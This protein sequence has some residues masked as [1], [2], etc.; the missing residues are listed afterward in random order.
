MPDSQFCRANG[1]DRALRAKAGDYSGFGNA[2]GSFARQKPAESYL[3]LR[4]AT[5]RWRSMLMPDSQFCRANG[6][7]RALRAK[8]GDYSGVC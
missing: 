4:P 6:K 7:D 1:K 3:I 2:P 8:A 5:N